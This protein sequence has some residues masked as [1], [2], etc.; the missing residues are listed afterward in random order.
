MRDR[1][2]TP[3]PDP[4]LLVELGGWFPRLAVRELE[5]VAGRWPRLLRDRLAV[6]A[7]DTSALLHLGASRTVHRDLGGFS[8]PNDLA[9]LGSL[10]GS[11]AV[12]FHD[13]DG[14][15]SALDKNLVI[16]SIWRSQS[17][18]VVD[19]RT[20]DHD[21]HV[22]ALPDELRIGELVGRC[23]PEL[24][25]GTRRP[26]VRSYEM[27]P[28]RARVLVNLSGATR[29][30]RFLDP[31]AGTGSLVIEAHRVG[32]TA[33]GADI[34]TRAAT[35]AARNAA[36]DRADAAFLTTD[37]GAAG[38]RP[39]SIDAAA[40]DLPY[41]RSARVRA[42]TR[43]DLYHRVLDELATLLTPGG[44]AVVV[45]V[46]GDEPAGEPAGWT[47]SWSTVEDARTVRRCT[48]VWERSPAA[49]D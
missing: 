1:R 9:A 8:G 22:F 3:D 34:E 18:P 17:S 47:R 38:L 26:V 6:V 10:G 42:T 2:Q 13:P 32:A 41:G 37:A 14:R 11:F 29:G 15:L 27:P 21:L 25:L 28:R 30:R 45:S 12:R 33:I 19:L 44:R 5:A 35:G 49:N 39:R 4:D 43:T 7:G 24:V 36:F 48:T 20:P 46:S 31:C 16:R 23:A 40:T